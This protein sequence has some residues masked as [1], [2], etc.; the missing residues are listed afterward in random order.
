MKKLFT[1]LL[2]IGFAATIRIIEGV[3]EMNDEK[4]R[5]I[6]ISGYK[7]ITKCNLSISPIRCLICV[8][9]QNYQTI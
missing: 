2:S 7:S 3:F 6:I 1:R 4:L 5:K 8:Y 9:H